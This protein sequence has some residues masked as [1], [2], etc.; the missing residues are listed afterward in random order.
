[1]TKLGLVPVVDNG[2]IKQ[3]LRLHCDWI[4]IE[5]MN[6]KH[7]HLVKVAAAEKMLRKLKSNYV[8]FHIAAG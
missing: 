3:I 1:M 6:S 8:H 4:N 7:K 2:N 5:S